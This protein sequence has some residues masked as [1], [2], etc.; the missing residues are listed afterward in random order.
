VCL[1]RIVPRVSAGAYV[2]LDDDN[3][4][5]GCRRAVDEFLGTGPSVD[6]VARE[7]NFVFRRR[8]AFT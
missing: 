6:I 3:E 5:G 2:V 1:E 7:S 8:A 4:Y